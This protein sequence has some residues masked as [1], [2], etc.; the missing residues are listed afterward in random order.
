MRQNQEPQNL[1]FVNWFLSQ[2]LARPPN[3]QK[4]LSAV[5]MAAWLRWEGTFRFLSESSLED[6]PV[7]AGLVSKSH[8]FNGENAWMVNYDDFLVVFLDRVPTMIA[9]DLYM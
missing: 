8:A 5:P 1:Q 2:N 3:N 4:T 6:K 7:A 9:K